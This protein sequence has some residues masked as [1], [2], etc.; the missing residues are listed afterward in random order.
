[1]VLKMEAAN[2]KRINAYQYKFDLQWLIVIRCSNLRLR[3][4]NQQL[5][6]AVGLHLGSKTCEKRRCICGKDVTEDEWRVLF[7][8]KSGGRFPMHSCLKA[9][10]KQS[11]ASTHNPFVLQPRHLQRTDQKQPDGSVLYHEL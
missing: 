6:I 7:C 11:L 8:L 4:S 5:R 3:L 1:M 9:F 10:I 2:V